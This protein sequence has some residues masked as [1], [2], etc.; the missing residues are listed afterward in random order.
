MLWGF[1]DSQQSDLCFFPVL[2]R[3][4]D[5]Q[6]IWK[7]HSRSLYFILIFI[8]ELELNLLGRV[9]IQV[10]SESW[11]PSLLCHIL[12]LLLKFLSLPR[13]FGCQ[14]WDVFHC[15][16]YISSFSCCVG[17]WQVPGSIV[18]RIFTPSWLFLVFSSLSWF[19]SF[20]SI[21]FLHLHVYHLI[22]YSYLADYY[23]ENCG[24]SEANMIGLLQY[25]A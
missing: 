7:M 17:A 18:P 21:L 3:K 16:T 25:F 6:T 2:V 19:S 4:S 22:L 8:E 5:A 24:M 23:L 1:F 20:S 15:F 10:F 13:H 11:Y 14:L 12:S 9:G